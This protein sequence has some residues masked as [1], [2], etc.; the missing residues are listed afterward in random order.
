M[1]VRRDARPI[2]PA[3]GLRPVG[4][5]LCKIVRVAVVR[6]SR[7]CESARSA[8]LLRGILQ[9]WHA[10]GAFQHSVLLSTGR[11]MDSEARQQDLAWTLGKSCCVEGSNN[12]V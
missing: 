6:W 11:L 12:H 4:R 1:P 8:S 2:A 7:S 3:N 5:R 10:G 9:R